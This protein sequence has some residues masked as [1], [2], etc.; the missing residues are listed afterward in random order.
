MQS[1]GAAL[2]NQIIE[3]LPWTCRTVAISKAEVILVPQFFEL[4]HAVDKEE[5]GSR[6]PFSRTANALLQFRCQLDHDLRQ[7]MPA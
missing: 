2:A 5:N 7:V 3:L 1:L 4:L 6:L